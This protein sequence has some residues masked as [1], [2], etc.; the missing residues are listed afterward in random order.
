[1]REAEVHLFREAVA[2][3]VLLLYREVVAR[4][5]AVHL[6]PEAA[7]AALLLFQEAAVLAGTVLPYPEA[8]VQA[9]VTLPYPEA[10]AAKAA[11]LPYQE[12]AVRARVVLPYP[13]AAVQVAAEAQLKS[14][15]VAADPEVAEAVLPPGDKIFTIDS[16]RNSP[17][18]ISWGSFF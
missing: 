14:L 8:A 9:R 16:T 13:E 4:E 10:V 1:M 7:K 5:E 6:Y 17:M 3:Q 11:L 18:I 15:E 2:A 12:V